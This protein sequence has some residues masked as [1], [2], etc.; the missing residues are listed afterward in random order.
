MND[1]DA[2]GAILAYIDHVILKIKKDED[3]DPHPLLKA[4]AIAIDGAKENGNYMGVSG[5][6]N[7]EKGIEPTESYAVVVEKKGKNF[8]LKDITDLATGN[9]LTIYDALLLIELNLKLEKIDGNM[10]SEE[11]VKQ[12]LNE[13]LRGV[14][15]EIVSPTNY[16]AARNYLK[17]LMRE[18]KVK[19]PIDEELK[20][21]LLELK[22]STKWEEYN[23]KVRGLI[24]SIWAARKGA[25]GISIES[26]E[27]PKNKVVD[28]F[29]H[30]FTGDIK[31]MVL[32]NLK[33]ENSDTISI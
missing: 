6:G 16:I 12:I 28:I 32:N 21:G 2:I 13:V 1:E 10:V 14:S 22:E 15:F 24:A 5:N 9:E 23:P 30:F 3:Y 29:R 33:Q 27:I 4:I 26:T 17:N 18:G 7:A 20:R 8:I 31:D 11:K 19:L 25:Y